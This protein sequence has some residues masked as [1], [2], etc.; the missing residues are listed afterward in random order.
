MQT[1]KKHVGHA[2]SQFELTNYLLNNLQ[3]FKITPVEKL[4]LLELSACYNPNKAD[5]FPK[6]KTLAQKIGISE[7]SVVRAIQ[8]LVNVGLIL[9]ECKYTNRYKFTSKIALW[10]EQE[11][12]F[13]EK[14]LSSSSRQNFTKKNDNL[15][16]HEQIIGTN[17]EPKKN[18]LIL[19]DYAKQR[20]AKNITAYVNTLK[21]NGSA[22]KILADYRAKRNADALAKQEI[23]ETRKHNEM[24]RD[25]STAEPPT[26]AWRKIGELLKEKRL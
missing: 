4:V 26:D 15:S 19:N 25:V 17:K 13:C 20:G 12:K 3:Q 18:D 5:M 9:V 7:R 10:S 2:F 1:A 23:E 22:I 14:S 8:S 24:I 21:N 11:K 16:S 6:Q